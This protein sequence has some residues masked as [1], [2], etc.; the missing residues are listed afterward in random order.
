[1]GK[2]IAI[3]WTNASRGMRTQYGLASGLVWAAYGCRA[4]VG[5]KWGDYILLP[6]TQYN[7]TGPKNICYNKK[8]LNIFFLLHFRNLHSRYWSEK[9]LPFFFDAK[10][11]QNSRGDQGVSPWQNLNQHCQVDSLIL[12]GGHFWCWS[13]WCRV[14]CIHVCVP[15]TVRYM[16]WITNNTF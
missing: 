10:K 11:S 6:H 15:Y 1:M 3:S 9:V 8:N 14:E 7:I 12:E 16:P 4:M 2:K 13:E 5:A